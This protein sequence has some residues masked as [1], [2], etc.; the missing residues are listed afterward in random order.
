MSPRIAS[1]FLA[2]TLA[3]GAAFA[4]GGDMLAKDAPRALPVFGPVSVAW[5]DPAKFSDLTSSGNRNAAARGDW[6]VQLATYLRKRADQRIAPGNRLE[7][8][9]LDI[10]RA[11]R[12][13]PWR[14]LS[15]QDTRVI[16]S[17]YAPFMV[18]K[19]REL[20]ASGSVV[21]EGERRITDP[22]FLVGSGTLNNGDPLR[23]EKRMIDSWLRREF[24]ET[25]AAR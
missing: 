2:L 22:A 12:Y 17:N 25:V 15:S 9:I 10:Q 24:P 1:L 4:A 14:G 7:L 13:E 6:L 18:V 19:F 20:D 5:S 8:T 21:A 3:S 11:G 23:Y 16:R